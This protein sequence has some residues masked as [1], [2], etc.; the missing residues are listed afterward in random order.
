MQVFHVQAEDGLRGLGL[1]RGVGELYKRQ[2]C[3]C[4][5]CGVWVLVCVCMFTYVCMCVCICV[6]M[7][8]CARVNVNVYVYVCVCS[9][10][11]THLT[12]PTIYTV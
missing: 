7:F 10:P 9:V 11:D 6:C 12:L 3:V 1:S 2:V 8:V 5:V 4:G